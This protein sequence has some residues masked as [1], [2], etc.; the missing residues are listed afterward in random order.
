MFSSVTTNKQEFYFSSNDKN[1]N[2]EDEHYEECDDNDID[3]EDGIGLDESI[4]DEYEDFED[5]LESD[6]PESAD[7]ENIDNSNLVDEVEAQHY[8]SFDE[9]D[10]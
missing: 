6:L 10:E 1:S 5:E 4:V 8:D 3:F 9:D 2:S 7:T